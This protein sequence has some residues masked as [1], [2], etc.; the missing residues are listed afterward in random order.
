MI[1][2]TVNQHCLSS[3]SKLAQTHTVVA[4]DDIVDE[5]GNKLWAKGNQVNNDLTEKLLRRKLAKP[6]EAT[7]TVD[8]ALTM[9]DIVKACH[10]H[11]E[12]HPLLG[13]IAGKQALKLLDDF[14][15]F[16]LPESMRLLLTS[17]Q[18]SE[19]ITFRHTLG[20]LLV[21]AG[22]AAMLQTSEHDTRILILATLLH[23][24]GELYINPEYLKNS[25]RLQPSEWKHIVSHPRIGQLLVEE[26][27]MLPSSIGKCIAHHHER[28]DGS[29]Y[30]MQIPRYGHHPLANLLAI[31][32]TVTPILTDGDCGAPLRAALALRV[33]PDEYEREAVA[34]VTRALRSGDPC[35]QQDK[36][37]CAG[38]VS[39][40]ATWER[41]AQ[42]MELARK[43]ADTASHVF[44]QRTAQQA[45]ALLSRLNHS[46]RSTGI[47]ELGPFTDQEEEDAELIL[48]ICQVER[49]LLWRMRHLARNI[50][51]RAD[52]Q[53]EQHCLTELAPLIAVLNTGEEGA[54]A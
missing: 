5:R 36:L 19:N 27:T 17:V 37:S 13:R 51:L 48:E 34:A 23:D 52:Q 39:A 8:G 33:I 11:L 22:I 24:M 54:A 44:V 26:L 41:L 49:E 32:D 1:F 47:T 20:T 40:Q 9:A 25:H 10:Q 21:S 50:H 6:L 53:E 18:H 29:G 42:A 38:T 14:R 7:L 28:Y 31:A 43:L 45:L 16:P 15:S 3:L 2:N 35:L 46:L 12:Q 4:A 30:P